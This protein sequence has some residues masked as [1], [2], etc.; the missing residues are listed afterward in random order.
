MTDPQAHRHDFHA[1][2][3]HLGLPPADRTDE[4]PEDVEAE[5]ETISTTPPAATTDLTHLPFV[6]IDPP[7]SLDLDQAVLLERVGDA[8]RVRYAIADLGSAIPPGG[9]VDAEARRRGQTLYLP[10]GRVPLHP[11]VLSEGSLSLL[12]DQVRGAAVWTIDVAADGSPGPATVQRAL[13]RS[14]ARLDYAGVQADVDAGTVHPSV[15]ALADLGRVRRTVRLAAGAID[16]ALPEQKVVPAGDDWTLTIDARTEVDG[17]NAE[18]SLLTGMSAAQLMLGAGIGLLRTLPT[19]PDEDVAAF[20]AMAATLGIES[21]PAVSPGT[22]LAGLDPTTPAAL[23]LMTHATRLL[24]GAGYV[25]FDGEVPD[26]SVHAGIGGAYAHVTA[27][28]RR[29]VDRFATE[30]CLAISAGQP[31][32]DWARAALPEIAATMRESDRRAA[33]ADRSTVDLVETWVMEPRRDEDFDA[34]VLRADEDGASVM[35]VDP[36]IE[37]RCS[38]TGLVDGSTIR[39][40]VDRLDESKRS[41][42]YLAVGGR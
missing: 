1:V 40:R 24:R 42:T 8:I 31:V 39:V 16:L 21:D 36:P 7:G 11:T 27:P 2:R 18:V 26:D 23:A 17:W 30:V 10:D 19:P 37:A 38:G 3:S 32:P 34:I 41:V 14:V 9:K 29:L 28:L 4:F 22:V 25:A 12:P 5:A 20:H 13:V 6:T 33:D 15:E 35:I